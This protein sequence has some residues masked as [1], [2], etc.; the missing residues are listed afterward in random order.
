MVI[1]P[2]R[3][4]TTS[5]YRAWGVFGDLQRQIHIDIISGDNMNIS[6]VDLEQVDA[7]FMQRP[8]KLGY[9]SL[10]EFI[11]SMNI[12]LW[13]DYDDNLL[14]VPSSNSSHETYASERVR[15]E[16]ANV[17]KIA[18]VVSVS[19]GRL[20]KYL[21]A[22]NKNI[23][24]I[25]NAFNERLFRH[26]K[27]HGTAPGDKIAWRGSNTHLLDLM[28]YTRG[29]LDAME[30]MKGWEWHFFGYN[31]FFLTDYQVRETKKIFHTYYQ[32]VIPYHFSLHKLHPKVMYV[33][34]ADS[35]FN[36]CKSN[37]NYIEATIAGAVTVCPDWEAWQVP[38]AIHYKDLKSFTEILKG[39]YK[40]KFDLEKR[41][42]EAYQYVMDELRLEV[43]NKK[44]IAVLE[45]LC[46]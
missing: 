30:K 37:I 45:S 43:V 20:R 25:P 38:G 14:E 18:D 2:Q 33:S 39:I 21:M 16:I 3:I 15:A 34:L 1:T 23:H 5:F 22:F 9:Y 28:S 31:P 19:T 46:N 10:C 4:D 27:P 11:K 32:D 7:V 13:V 17:V 41:Q 8:Y 29:I 35:V 26:L 36:H 42:K 6:W 44:R 12:P 40:G 24:V